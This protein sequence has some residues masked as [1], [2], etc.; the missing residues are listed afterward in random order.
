MFGGLHIEMSLFS[1][2]GDVLDGS[3]WIT[4]LVAANIATEGVAQSF[5]SASHLTRTRHAH[6]VTLITLLELQ[7]YAFAHSDSTENLTL[8]QW[9]EDRS[10]KVRNLLFLAAHY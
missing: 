7:R 5:L 9:S 10:K 4:A 8:Q 2:L 6:Q 1:A 3:G